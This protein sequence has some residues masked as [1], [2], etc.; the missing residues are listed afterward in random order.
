MHWIDQYK[1]HQHNNTCAP[2]QESWYIN[3]KKKIISY[4]HNIHTI[5]FTAC[6]L[7][8]EQVMCTVSYSYYD[9][10]AVLQYVKGKWTSFQCVL[11]SS[12]CAFQY[13]TVYPKQLKRIWNPCITQWTVLIYTYNYTCRY[14]SKSGTCWGCTLS[15]T[16]GK[17]NNVLTSIS[18]TCCTLQF[19]MKCTQVNDF[20]V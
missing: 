19:I 11:H 7:Q 18:S 2:T 4:Q 16:W 1:L 8:Y 20:N 17:D 5:P 9:D 13:I 6:L 14:C 12:L 3:D 10:G 15:V